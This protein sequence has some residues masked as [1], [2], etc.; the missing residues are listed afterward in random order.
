M[1]NDASNENAYSV[2]RTE[3]DSSPHSHHCDYTKSHK[4]L[5]VSS[6]VM[7]NKMHMHIHIQVH[8]L[9]YKNQ[10]YNT[11][12]ISIIKLNGRYVVR[13]LTIR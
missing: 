12:H 10:D 11:F 13:Y 4:T 1:A 7:C 8:L 5:S 9:R 2:I 6:N 3:E